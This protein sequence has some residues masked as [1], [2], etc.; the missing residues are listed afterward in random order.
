ME[1]EAEKE[2]KETEGRWLKRLEREQKHRKQQKIKISVHLKNEKL[3]LIFFC[4]LPKYTGPLTE[5]MKLYFEIKNM[6]TQSTS[7]IISRGR[8]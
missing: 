1:R 7:P 4:T 3:K 2:K 8:R 6:F 5:T